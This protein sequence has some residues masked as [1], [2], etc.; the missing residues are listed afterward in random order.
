[1]HIYIQPHVIALFPR[2]DPLPLFLFLSFS[3]PL[4]SRAI[5]QKSAVFTSSLSL[6]FLFPFF[7]FVGRVNHTEKHTEREKGGGGRN[8]KPQRSRVSKSSESTKP[9]DSLSSFF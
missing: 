8:V 9:V 5:S 3:I 6:S 1:M 7:F 4:I 2:E